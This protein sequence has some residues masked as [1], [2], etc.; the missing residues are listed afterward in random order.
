MNPR[1]NTRRLIFMSAVVAALL[2]MLAAIATAAPPNCEELPFEHRHYCGPPPNSTTTTT[3]TTPPPTLEAC[4]TETFPI[5]IPKTGRVSYECL[6]TPE[7]PGFLPVVGKVTVTPGDGI[8]KLGVWVRDS[9]PGDICLLVQGA[10]NQTGD[11]GSFVGSFDLSYGDLPDDEVWD[12]ED[13]YPDYA[14]YENKTYWSLDGPH[15]CYPQDP[16][17][18][19]RED[20]NGRPLHLSVGFSAK[21]NA[22]PVKVTLSVEPKT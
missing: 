6:W 4:P 18:G 12:P 10:E 16:S 21:K 7:D 14:N 2:L 13:L 9:A 1:L 3:T 5:P 8:S 17:V 22:D 20:P 11:D 19:M 15:W